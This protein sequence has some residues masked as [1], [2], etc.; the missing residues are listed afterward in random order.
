[1]RYGLVVGPSEKASDI[2][3][4]TT[5]TKSLSVHRFFV[6]TCTSSICGFR[7]VT[8]V[9]TQCDSA[10][11]PELSPDRSQAALKHSQVSALRLLGLSAPSAAPARDPIDAKTSPEWL[12]DFRIDR[13]W[14][15]AASNVR[16]RY[17][18]LAGLG[19]CFKARSV[20]RAH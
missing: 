5:T 3:T 15:S 20:A 12:A 13:I 8:V 14:G 11:L 4:T 6:S 1:M 19:E 9:W 16:L 18:R 7:C 17:I 10:Q 2:H